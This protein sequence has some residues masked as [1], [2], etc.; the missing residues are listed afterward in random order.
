[1][2][3]YTFL[4]SERLVQTAFFA[5]VAAIAIAAMLPTFVRSAEGIDAKRNVLRVGKLILWLL[6]IAVG[7][8]YWLEPRQRII[9]FLALSGH[10]AL[11][12]GTTTRICSNCQQIRWDRWW[13]YSSLDLCR[14][15]AYPP[16]SK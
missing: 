8:A 9:A 3:D 1:M 2:G 16:A 13:A 7:F 12:I 14:D 6:L 15:C 11:H 5:A 4:L 10:F